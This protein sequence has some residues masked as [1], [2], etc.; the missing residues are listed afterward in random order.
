MIRV[1]NACL[2]FI[3]EKMH[4]LP[5]YVDIIEMGFGTNGDYA[6]I[7]KSYEVEPAGPGRPG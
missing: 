6:Q 4:D 5:Y 3:N 7:V 2:G 1:G